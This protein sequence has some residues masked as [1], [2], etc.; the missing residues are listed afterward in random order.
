[1]FVLSPT[2]SIN[3]C[4]KGSDLDQAKGVMFCCSSRGRHGGAV[5]RIADPQQDGCPEF[6]EKQALK[7]D[8]RMDECPAE[9]FHRCE[10]D[11]RGLMAFMSGG[12]S[13]NQMSRE[14]H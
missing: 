14:L 4:V 6:R 9:F 1:M 12:R 5:V 13:Q 7:M 3:I 10:A 8:G 2:L 11:V